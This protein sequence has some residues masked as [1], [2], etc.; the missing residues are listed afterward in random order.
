MASHS[1]T[2]ASG[3]SQKVA[4][5]RIN[6][7]APS[8]RTAI[9]AFVAVLILFRWL[10][11]ILALQITSTG[12]QIQVRTQDLRKN[13]RQITVLHN[14][15]AEAE[16]PKNLASRAIELGY[17]P[18]NPI[19]LPLAQ[20]QLPATSGEATEE[21]GGEHSLVPRDAKQRLLGELGEALS[22]WEET[23]SEP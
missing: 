14:H 8:L 6:A 15:I 10:H 22:I 23:E 5:A 19:Y 3:L 12:L 18:T 13:E 2:G 17:S 4:R 11:L 21:F 9:I 1:Q 20:P 16:S 7:R